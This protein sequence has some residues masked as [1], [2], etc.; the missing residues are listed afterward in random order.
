MEG[1][2]DRAYEVG[3]GLL[4]CWTG[5]CCIVVAVVC[6]LLVLGV[7][8][9]FGGTLGRSIVKR[10]PNVIKILLKPSTIILENSAAKAS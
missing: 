3:V 4:G 9:G 8:E 5:F 1:S 6:C 7:S 10:R 2:P